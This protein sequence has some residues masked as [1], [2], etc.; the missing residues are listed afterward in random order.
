MLDFGS[1]FRNAANDGN[2]AKLEELYQNDKTLMD[3][4]G[5]PSGL[6]ALHRATMK[7]KVD[8]VKWLL[9]HGADIHAGNKE[10][11]YM[12]GL[13]SDVPA[14]VELF[15]VAGLSR[16][17]LGPKTP[18][19]NLESLLKEGEVSFLDLTKLAR[20]REGIQASIMF[21]FKNW[22]NLSFVMS[23]NM[24]PAIQSLAIRTEQYFRND[25]QNP[26]QNKIRSLNTQI[27]MAIIVRL[28]SEPKLFTKIVADPKKKQCFADL[29]LLNA[30][31]AYEMVASKCLLN[32]TQTHEQRHQICK[33]IVVSLTALKRSDFFHEALSDQDLEREVLEL[34]RELSR[35]IYILQCL[36]NPNYMGF[37][38]LQYHIAR[39]NQL[40]K[41]S[42]GTYHAE[43]IF[44]QDI[45]HFYSIDVEV[46]NKLLKQVKQIKEGRQPR[47]Q[48]IVDVLG[49]GHAMLVDIGYSVTKN[50]LEV[51]CVEPACLVFQANFLKSF[52][53]GVASNQLGDVDVIAIQSELLKD[54]SSC[55]VFSLALSGEVSKLSFDEV[56]KGKTVSQPKFTNGYE[57]FLLE[58]MNGVL[59]KDISAL[60]V[61]VI[62]MGQSTTL[63]KHKLL[64]LFPNQ[65]E[66]VDNVI[67]DLLSDYHLEDKIFVLPDEVEKKK[68]Y[69]HARRY[70]L[71]QKLSQAHVS[72]TVVKALP[73]QSEDSAKKK[74]RVWLGLK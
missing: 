53:S 6:T 71:R 31:F 23:S 26:D 7:G 37:K 18:Q 27:L 59:W 38:E 45:S 40:S 61:K 5:Q 8:A 33:E 62:M 32:Q 47:T 35:K 10:T 17:T 15:L 2:I 55:Y 57:E 64:T 20:F 3:K 1:A 30:F 73:T 51:I 70:S 58:P 46:L 50:K 12:M 39:K 52:L 41:S 49:Q 66:K 42:K 9:D 4:Q 60:G 63:M 24:A 72:S 56:K 16:L 22:G 69:I 19:D 28:Q 48:F 67:K 54:Y 34:R 74:S 14:I 36:Y 43:V 13:K 11:P 25:S 29:C 44:N 65:A 21:A 68:S